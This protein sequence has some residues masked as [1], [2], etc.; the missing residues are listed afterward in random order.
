MGQSVY[1]LCRPLCD[2]LWCLP[3]VGYQMGQIPRQAGPLCYNEFW[4]EKHALPHLALVRSLI[5][6]F[7]YATHRLISKEDVNIRHDIHQGSLEELANKRCRQIQSEDLVVLSS[8][9]SH[10]QY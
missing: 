3:A 2:F 6:S 1:N 10:F 7:I 8:I 4:D 9:A 5:Y